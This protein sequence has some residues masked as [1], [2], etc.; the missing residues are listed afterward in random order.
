MVCSDMDLG[1]A[2]KKGGVVKLGRQ[3]MDISISKG[4][5]RMEQEMGFGFATLA[6]ARQHKINLF[7]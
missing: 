2:D 3:R 5:L 6:L 7:S 4:V 1:D